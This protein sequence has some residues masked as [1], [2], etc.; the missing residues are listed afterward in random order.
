RRREFV[1]AMDAFRQQA[2]A[3]KVTTAD[4]DLERAF[5]LIASEDAKAA[6]D[7]ESEPDEVRNRYGRKTIGQSCLL[8][9]RL[10]ERGVSF[11][12]VNNKGWDT[13]ADLVTRLKDG[14]VGAKTPGGLI[15]SLDQAFSGL[16]EDLRERGLLDETLVLVMGEFGRTPKLNVQGGRDHWPRV[17]SIAMAGGGV[18]GGQVYGSSDSVGESPEDNPVTPSDLVAT[19]FELLGLSPSHELKTK[20]GRPVLLTPPEARVIRELIA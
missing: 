4:P 12:T 2:D 20:D 9:R 13:H 8:A 19:V 7:L 1:H 18:Q 11:V 15:P 3:G 6:F 14:Y 5:R 10:I 16:I 17:F